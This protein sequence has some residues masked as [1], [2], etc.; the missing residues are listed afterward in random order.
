MFWLS[1]IPFEERLLPV[2]STN[3]TKT[4]SGTSFEGGLNQIVNVPDFD[5]NAIYLGAFS[6][7]S[8]GV[9]VKL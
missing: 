6:P 2:F 4:G 7:D 1:F 3:G 5:V 9:Q 8:I